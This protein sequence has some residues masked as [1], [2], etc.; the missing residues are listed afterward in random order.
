[1][2]LPPPEYSAVAKARH[3]VYERLI[4]TQQSTLLTAMQAQL[5]VLEDAAAAAA[6]AAAAAATAALSS[7]ISGN[8]GVSGAS[9]IVPVLDDEALLK[10]ARLKNEIAEIEYESMQDVPYKL[11][12]EEATLYSNE[13]KS[14]SLRVATLEKH[15]GQAFALIIGQCTQ[16][17]L[18]KMKQEKK[19]E[20]VSA[21][22]DPL[23]LYKLIEC[24]VLKQTEDQYVV[25]AMWDQYRQV[26]N[27]QQGTLSNTLYYESLRTKFE[28]A[29]LSG[30][31][32]PM[33]GLVNIVLRMS[34][35]HHMIQLGPMRR[36]KWMIQLGRGS[37]RMACYEQAAKIMITSSMPCRMILPREETPTLK[38]LNRLSCCWISTQ[39][40]Q[41]SLLSR[42]VPHLPRRERRRGALRRSRMLL[43][44]R[45]WSLTKTSTRIRSVSVAV[46]WDT[47]RQLAQ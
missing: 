26:Y 39:R 43:I 19:W 13:M 11:N 16:L 10:I 2:V 37:S 15:R 38:L 17:L 5:K 32:S 35:R 23:E 8:G 12:G 20:A 3:V 27:S 24:V 46:S 40:L 34:S 9:S 45:R 22:Y 7:T 25:A 29:G 18:D 33:T 21:S 44:P 4:R 42:R 14:H 36:P 41:L 31:S 6:T 30:V 1:V 28:V 47:P